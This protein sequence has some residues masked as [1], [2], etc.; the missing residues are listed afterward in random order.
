MC[1]VFFYYFYLFYR[2]EFILEN[3]CINSYNEAFNFYHEQIKNFTSEE[4]PRTYSEIFASLR[5]L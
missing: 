5:V 1:Y 3:K 2:W 4:A